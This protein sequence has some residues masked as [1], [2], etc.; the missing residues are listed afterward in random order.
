M[1]DPMDL[2]WAS[3][4]SERPLF[5]EA[6]LRLWP[7]DYGRQLCQMGLLRLAEN[8]TQ[9]VCPGC[10]G[11]HVEPVVPHASPGGVRFYVR[12]PEA[13]R[14]EVPSDHLRQW[15]VDL[16]ALVKALASAMMP[17]ARSREVVPGRLWKLCKMPWRESQREM[18][19]SRGLGW[20]DSPTVASRIPPVSKPIVLVPDAAPPRHLW[21]KNAPAV[22]ALSRV[23]T[24]DDGKVA[25]DMTDMAAVVNEA[26][27]AARLS[28][29]E[30]LHEAPSK[31]LTQIVRQAQLA[32]LTDEALVRAYAEHGSYRKA[33]DALVTDGHETDRW[34]V[35]RAVQ[36]MGGV[37]EVRRIIDSQSVRRTVVSQRR[38][39]GK[40][41]LQYPQ[42][43][44]SE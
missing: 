39:S 41:P 7:E 24:V 22:V 18:F 29:A 5:T 26:D 1:T 19:L 8:A 17:R 4:E 27:M 23:V 14:V 10:N 31:K 37:K 20:P 3:L 9:V 38:D 21:L 34:A 30:T 11:R 32:G 44:D 12:C 25:I 40:R 15:T 36:R 42:S 16:T 2:F 35:E 43:P 33:A 13:L 6:D 28:A